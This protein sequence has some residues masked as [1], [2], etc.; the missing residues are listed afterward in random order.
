MDQVPNTLLAQVNAPLGSI[1]ESC[2]GFG[3]L[4]TLTST[5]ESGV[6]AIARVI[7]LIVGLITICAGIYFMIQFLIGGF[8]WLSAS[9]DKSRLTK[10]QD[11]LVHAIVGLIIV[12]AAFGIATIVQA[13]LGIDI[14]LTNPGEIIR[15]L[16]GG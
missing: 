4:C 11:R 15:Q 13:I 1:T 6:S 9:G 16:G 7:S 10:A 2:E 8:E 12:V 14:L 5:G 3:F